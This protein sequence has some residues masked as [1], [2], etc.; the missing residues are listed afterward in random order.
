M[1]FIASS[2][3]R[4][5]AQRKFAVRYFQIFPAADLPEICPRQMEL[6]SQAEKLEKIFAIFNN[7]NDYYK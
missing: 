1:F 7:S 4:F 5:R 6:F 2:Q 3:F